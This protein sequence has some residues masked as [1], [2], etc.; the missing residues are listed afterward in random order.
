MC[1][2]SRFLADVSSGPT[3]RAFR[4]HV[5]LNFEVVRR[6][7]FCALWVLPNTQFLVKEVDN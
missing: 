1:L 7:V 4:R 3:I 2:P 6:G 5:T